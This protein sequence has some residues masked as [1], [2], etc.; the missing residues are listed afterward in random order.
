MSLRT[1]FQKR[2]LGKSINNPFSKFFSKI[3][4]NLLIKFSFQAR[5]LATVLPLLL[6]T[7]STVAYISYSKTKETTLTL[8]EQRLDTEM[9]SVYDIAQNVTL[10]HVGDNEKFQKKMEQV[11]KNQHAQLSQ[12]KMHA[13]FFLI[14]QQEI[15]PF[16]VSQNTTLKINETFVD[17]IRKQENGIIAKEING[18]MYTLAFTS[19]QELKGIY[20]I[21]LPQAQF[22]SSLKEMSTTIMIWALFGIVATSL[23][24][25]FL[26]RG[27]T[28]PLSTLRELMREA[29]N[30][31]LN[32]HM[33]TRTTT[34]EITSLVK[35]FHAMITQMRE[36]LVNIHNTT[37]NLSKT[38]GELREVSEDVIEENRKLMSA[39]QIVRT[40]AEQTASS[41]EE[42]INLFQD[43]KKS[44]VHISNQIEAIIEKSASMNESASIGEENIGSL[45][46]NIILFNQEF[47]AVTETVHQVQEH[48]ASIA[49]VIVLI[50][51]V[52]EQTKLLALNAAIEAA[53]AGEAGKGFAVVANEVRKLAEQS[54]QATEEITKTINEMGSISNQASTEFEHVLINFQKNLEVASKSR[55]SFDVLMVDIEQV[56]EV[57]AGVQQEL[58]AL[59]NN[60]PKMEAS[61]EYFVSMSQQTLA[62]AEQMIHISEEEMKKVQISYEAGRKLID[63]SQAL[64]KLTYEFQFS[65]K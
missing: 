17:E 65:Q 46:E 56:N 22:L 4:G 37:D 20:V 57:I 7:V 63:L 31:N 1:K 44:I 33:E 24:L 26:V 58:L 39:I 64:S 61:S 15:K 47:R 8:I 60:L 51:Q 43:T 52:A 32:V 16:K 12:D 11:I 29:R 25:I 40:G 59:N 19:I 36:L 23:I 30:G 55:Q 5:I 45:S 35:S 42:S 28:K 2:F 49:K 50:Q 38:G 48:S 34:P 6:I 41:S 53:R 54:S 14:N 10:A 62:S 9:R 21:A 3:F 13:D 18:N 27:L